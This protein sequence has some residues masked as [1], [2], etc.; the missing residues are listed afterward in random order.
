MKRHGGF[1]EVWCWGMS[2]AM[3]LEG[4]TRTKFG[5][6]LWVSLDLHIY[7]SNGVESEMFKKT[8]K[9]EWRDQLESYYKI[10]LKP[11]CNNSL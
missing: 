6:A 3:K 5:R 2:Q 7:V 10:I 11:L 9:R 8:C 4:K 1:G